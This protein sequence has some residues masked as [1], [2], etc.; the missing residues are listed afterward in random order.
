MK[1]HTCPDCGAKETNA[2]KAK[3]HC[4]YVKKPASP[5]Y[6]Y[7]PLKTIL[8]TMRLNVWDVDG[9]NF[10]YTAT[11]VQNNGTIHYEI[12]D[13]KAWFKSFSDYI[14]SLCEDSTEPLYLIG[15]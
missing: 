5:V 11:K 3:Y 1:L 12:D 6:S 4:A 9:D 14:A 7:S 13:A 10:I 2:T 8:A 15:A